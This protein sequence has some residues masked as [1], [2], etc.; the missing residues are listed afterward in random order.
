VS[1]TPQNNFANGDHIGIYVVLM[2]SLCTIFFGIRKL[3]TTERHSGMVLVLVFESIVKLTA[4]LMVGIFV[5]YF[6]N[7]GIDDLLNKLPTIASANFSFM[8]SDGDTDTIFYN[9]GN[10]QRNR[11][12][13]KHLEFDHK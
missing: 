13:S 9:E 10:W 11:L 4:F 12:G 3:N 2:V 1:N 6:L 5:T 7:H 8:G